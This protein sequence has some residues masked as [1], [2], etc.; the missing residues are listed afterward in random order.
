MN[1]E[2]CLR[3]IR[4]VSEKTDTFII[5]QTLAENQLRKSGV[6]FFGL[7]GKLGNTG[8]NLEKFLNIFHRTVY[9]HEP[10]HLSNGVLITECQKNL[11]F[12]YNTEI[13]QC[14]PG[15]NKGSDRLP[16]KKEIF[17]C[18]SKK[19]LLKEIEIIQPKLI[20]LMGRISYET[21]FKYILQEINIPNLSNH[22]SENSENGI[23]IK[24]L[25]NRQRIP[26]LAIQHASGANPR[27]FDMLL[28]KPL[29]NNI[30]KIIS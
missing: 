14:Y 26:V 17:N 13:C 7:D 2:K 29:I 21:F 23:S 24:N 20:L 25:P 22:I 4:A 15:K 11:S 18:I 1:P 28:N 19:F 12:V 16:N 27:F 30:S 8:K 9:P 5:S 6:N 10:I 3:S